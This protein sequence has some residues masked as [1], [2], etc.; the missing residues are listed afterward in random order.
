MDTQPDVFAQHY[1]GA[2]L[3]KKFV[4]YW[5]KAGRIHQ[6]V[7]MWHIAKNVP[8]ASNVR[9]S[10]S[11]STEPL[12]ASVRNRRIAARLSQPPD[13]DLTQR[14]KVWFKERP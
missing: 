12:S 5:G 1:A 7:Q 6:D 11:L 4:A 10:W 3:V 2:G 9:Y 14:W 13:G 8:V